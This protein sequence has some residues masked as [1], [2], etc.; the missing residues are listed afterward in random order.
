MKRPQDVD[1]SHDMQDGVARTD[2]RLALLRDIGRALVEASSEHDALAT[3]VERI[4]ASLQWEYGACWKEDEQTHH[5]TCSHIWNEP[6]LAGSEFVQFSRNAS[7]EPGSGGLVRAALRLRQPYL[8]ED[9]STLPGFLRA[10]AAVAAGLRSAFAFPLVLRGQ[11]LGA[12]EFFCRRARVP[13]DALTMTAVTLGTMVGEYL[14]RRD[15]D[16]RY[17]ELV[18]LSPDAIVVHCEGSY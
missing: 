16:A 15:A 12:M 13:D 1:E 2:P 18:E 17:R 7:F 9:I 4:C 14:A 3:I 10:P 8:V 5:I 6:A 11:T